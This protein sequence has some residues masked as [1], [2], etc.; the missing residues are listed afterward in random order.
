VIGVVQARM[1]SARLSGKVL[2]PLG[3]G[4]VLELLVRRL[5]GARELD[6]VVIATSWEASDAPI[7]TAAAELGVAVVR[8]PLNDVLERFRLAA[9]ATSAEAV[10]RITADCPLLDPAVVD[11]VVLRWRATGADYAA[12]TLGPCSYPDGMD[13]EVISATALTSAAARATDPADREHVTSY[14]RERPEEFAAAGLWLAPPHGSARITLDTPADLEVLRGLVA[15]IGADAPLARI[16]EALGLS[17][18]T[19]VRTTPT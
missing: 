18:T 4:T 13:V 7:V 16:L 6:E 17:A 3:Q 15:K 1:S 11:D 14:V 5:G 2:A 9:A 19:V 8:G 12:N 10:A